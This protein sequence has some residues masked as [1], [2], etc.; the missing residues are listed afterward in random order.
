M[1]DLGVKS[2]EKRERGFC[3]TSRQNQRF[4]LYVVGEVQGFHSC[5]F[6]KPDSG[7]CVTV[8]T[9]FS[10]LSKNFKFQLT[11]SRHYPRHFLYSNS[12]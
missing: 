12:N 6:D 2:A 5:A 7:K 4:D 8:K 10:G 9:A 11:T 3:E 1:S